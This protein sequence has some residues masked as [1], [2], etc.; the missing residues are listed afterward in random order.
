MFEIYTII[1][2]IPQLEIVR[3]KNELGLMTECVIIN[4]IFADAI[5]GEIVLRL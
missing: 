2:K 3:I 4:F 1:Q 5:I